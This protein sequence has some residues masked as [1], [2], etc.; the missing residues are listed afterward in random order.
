MAGGVEIGHLLGSLC[1]LEPR[2][3]LAS[4]ALCPDDPALLHPTRDSPAQHR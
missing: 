3:G 4:R 2:R 1:P